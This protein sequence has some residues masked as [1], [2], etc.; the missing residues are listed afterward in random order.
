MKSIL[1]VYLPLV[2]TY[3]AYG[4]SVDSTAAERPR[5]RSFSSYN[6]QSKADRTFSHLPGNQKHYVSKGNI[7]FVTHNLQLSAIEN[8]IA[9]LEDRECN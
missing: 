2:L 3:A 1:S 4:Q 8:E 9:D 7:V 6:S 5:S